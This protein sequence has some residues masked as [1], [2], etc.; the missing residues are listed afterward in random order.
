MNRNIGTQ[1]IK[2]HPINILLFH[3]FYIHVYIYTY[4]Y[5][6]FLRL[7]VFL[8]N[9]QEETLP[10]NFMFYRQNSKVKK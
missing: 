3:I 9:F 5:V 6:N 4:I 2:N 7:L 1:Y 8:A 10:V